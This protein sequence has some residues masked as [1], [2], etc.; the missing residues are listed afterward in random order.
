MI[1]GDRSLLR[2]EKGAFWYTLEEFSKHWERI[3]IICPRA[4]GRSEKGEVRRME[5]FFGNVFVHP[6]PWTLWHQ[7]K[8]IL[9]QGT[10]IWQAYR[11]DVMTVHEYPPFLNGSGAK[12][13]SAKTGIP[14]AI[15]I[16]HIVG[17]P[18]AADFKETIGR[19]MSRLY[20]SR[21]TSTAA[22]VRVVNKT[23]AELLPKW[24]VSKAKVRVVPSF[25]L[26]RTKLVPDASIQKKYDIAFCGRLV[27]NKGLSNVIHALTLLPDA[28]LLVVGDG[29]ERQA[30]HQL[31][32]KLG[33]EHRVEFLGWLPTQEAVMRQLQSAK[34]FVMNSK[35]EGGPRVALEAMAV[36][37][38][39]VA[40]KVGI[41]PEVIIDGRN[42][43]LTTGEPDD[44]AAKLRTLL[45]DQVL[46][47]QMSEAAKDVINRF[48]RSSLIARYAQFLQDLANSATQK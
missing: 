10:K 33:V 14:Y 8:W 3:D 23:V 26:D 32:K 9:E 29:P 34:V 39:I 25:Y 45:G 47:E 41:M 7:P 30:A 48:E 31:T 17:Y 38:P 36:G 24:G 27:S 22:A 4:E 44:L 5:S 43:M 42:G 35:S 18:V 46:R 37:L 15:E 19:W 12:K 6:S 1:S 40:T 13:L 20:L 16:H 21:D 2:G 28:T 11:P